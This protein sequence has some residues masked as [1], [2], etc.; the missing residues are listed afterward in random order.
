MKRTVLIITA[1]IL[2]F[3]IIHAQKKVAYVTT[4]MLF[5]EN[6]WPADNDVII[7]MLN[8]DPN[9]DL[10]VL[11]CDADGIIL[12]TQTEINLTGFDVI[13]AQEFFGS[14]GNIWKEGSPLYI[15]NLPAPTIYN[16]LYSLKQ[17]RA[18]PESLGNTLTADSVYSLVVK[19]NNHDIFKG[20]DI[21]SGKIQVSKGAA[22]TN[23]NQENNPKRCMH[24][25]TGNIIQDITMLAYPD[26]EY[27]IEPGLA[28]SD[29]APGATIDGVTIPTRVITFNMN[30][31]QFIAKG[32]DGSGCNLTEDGLKLWKNA[33]Y[34]VAGLYDTS[35]VSTTKINNS[36][37]YPVQGGIQIT[38]NTN[39]SVYSLSGQLITSEVNANFI[40]LKPGIYIITSIEGVTKVAV[41]R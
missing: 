1:F 26:G 27:D 4:D 39:A 23:G 30:Y 22:S 31:G 12:E 37:I 2:C 33:V 19:Q 35:P 6:T 15:G 13:I 3:T 16:K 41:N 38:A 7:Q 32:T 36:N 14:Q 8:K 25:N 40:A 18:L 10:T 9:I 24:Y 20:I 34:I 29:F 11:T 5:G 17:D 28:V 21:S